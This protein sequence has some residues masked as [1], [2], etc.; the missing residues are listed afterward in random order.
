[1][2]DYPII[3]NM[4]KDDFDCQ[5]K[6]KIYCKCKH[7]FKPKKK[8]AIRPIVFILAFLLFVA[9]PILLPVPS[10]MNKDYSYIVLSINLITLL[11]YFVLLP[12]PSQKKPLTDQ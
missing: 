12:F 9:D 8:T 7:E 10:F 3:K 11:F 5:E 1:M 6:A 4:L 2:N